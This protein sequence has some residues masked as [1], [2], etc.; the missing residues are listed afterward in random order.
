MCLL[1]NK[2]TQ[3]VIVFRILYQLQRQVNQKLDLQANSLW[4][5]RKRM[6]SQGARAQGRESV[7]QQSQ[8]QTIRNERNVNNCGLSN[9]CHFNFPLRE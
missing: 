2:I 1:I 3:A 9:A 4:Q 8:P 6:F 7:N 5:E